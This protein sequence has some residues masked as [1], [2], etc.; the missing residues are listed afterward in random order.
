MLSSCCVTI[1]LKKTAAVKSSKGTS[2]QAG[3]KPK[4]RGPVRL[5]VTWLKNRRSV[6]TFIALSSYL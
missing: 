3:E 2:Q 4:E 5:Q 1:P 6:V